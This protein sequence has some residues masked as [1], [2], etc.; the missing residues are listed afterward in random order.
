[1][2]VIVYQ[3]KALTLVLDLETSPGV[4]KTRQR[5]RDFRKR[6]PELA[7]ERNHA[8]RVAHVVPAGNVQNRLAQFLAPARHRKD[9][10]EIAQLNLGS[11]IIRRLGKSKGNRLR[12][13]G[14]NPQ[15][16]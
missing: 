12:M 11:A 1:M 2:R 8:E 7:R 15:R 14:T 6:H 4:L 13:A 5:G 16:M 9:R 10:R 3:E